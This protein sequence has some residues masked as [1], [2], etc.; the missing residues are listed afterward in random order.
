M[1]ARRITYIAE[2]NA[3]KTFTTKKNSLK[4]D[5]KIYSRL[6]NKQNSFLP[7]QKRKKSNRAQIAKTELKKRLYS[8]VDYKNV[9]KILYIVYIFM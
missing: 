7:S 8:F 1:H 2:H 4:K 3:R 9:V 5:L 6:K